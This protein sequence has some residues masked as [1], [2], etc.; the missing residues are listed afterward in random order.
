MEDLYQVAKSL[1][2]PKKGILAADWS[3]GTATKKFKN[4]EI[5]CTEESR[6]KYRQI[7]F[8]SL[9]LEEYIS[10]VILHDETIKQK[11]DDG[12]PFPDVL[13][14][15]GIIP[16]IRIDIGQVEMPKFPG[17][18]ISEGLDGVRE[19]M[20]EYKK[21]GAGFAKWRAAY[22]IS[23]I[24]PSRMVVIANAQ[25]H[26]LYAM[27]AMEAGLVPIVEPDLIIEGDH[28]IDDCAKATKTVCEL[29][30]K[31]LFDYDVDRK[32]MLLKPN[33]ILPG[34]DNNQKVDPEVVADKTLEVYKAVCP[35]D[36]PGIV[37]L[38]GGQSDVEATANL[39]AIVKKKA[40]LPW[41]ISFSYARAIQEP[42]LAA[43]KGKDENVQS[44]Q[45]AL[46]KRAK[47][48][49][50]ARMGEYDSSMEQ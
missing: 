34:K 44:A 30:F 9:G 5:E 41:Q 32:A 13:K 14:E 23:P 37:F 2:A 6:R 19:R 33:M 12:R 15:K 21:L 42:V 25:L 1:V 36:I 11:T 27:Y 28:S 20:Q 45:N 16:G 39:N 31:T 48:N 18:L 47:L 22:T 24:Q 35:V 17:E 29:T 49:S 3:V 26:A 7:L 4:H 8:T 40:N 46:L 10:G 43:W 50:L 38:S